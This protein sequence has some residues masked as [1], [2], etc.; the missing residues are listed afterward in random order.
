VKGVSPG[1]RSR[2]SS[3]LGQPTISARPIPR[4]HVRPS[5]GLQS[6]PVGTLVGRSGKIRQRKRASALGGGTFV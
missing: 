4:P 1:S 2:W 3:R 5:L 6:G